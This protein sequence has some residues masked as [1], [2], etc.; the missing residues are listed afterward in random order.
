MFRNA[1]SVLLLVVSTSLA[2]APVQVAPNGRYLVDADGRPF[3]VAGTCT[4]VTLRSTSNMAMVGLRLMGYGQVDWEPVPAIGPG[5]YSIKQGYA[6]VMSGNPQFVDLENLDG[7]F[8][9]LS[10]S[11]VNTFRTWVESAAFGSLETSLG[12]YSETHA[13]RIDTILDTADRYGIKVMLTP[14]D[15]YAMHSNFSSSIYSAAKGGPC[16][17][18]NEMLT[19]P[20]ARQY[21]K[22]LFQYMID[23]W[24]QHPALM[25]FDLMNEVNWALSSSPA[26]QEAWLNDVG[27]YVKQYE[28]TTLG[29]NHLLTCSPNNSVGGDPL[30]QNANLNVA[31][32]HYYDL[33]GVNT[34]PNPWNA[35]NQV[36]AAVRSALAKNPD[37]PYFDNEHS[38]FETTSL[39][40]ANMRETEHCT[41]WA[42]FASGAAGVGLRFHVP[43]ANYDLPAG[44][45]SSWQAVRTFSANID[46]VNF[47]SRNAA[48]Q[49]ITPANVLAAACA[50]DE[51][52][53]GWLLK[54]YYGDGSLAITVNGLAA[55]WHE[56]R[57]FD[58]TTGLQVSE[59]V[60]FLGSSWQGSTPAF[61]D[62]LAFTVQ[63]VPEPA[64]LALLAVGLLAVRRRRR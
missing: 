50:D 25:G 2:E 9:R 47:D 41:M 36:A 16:A 63:A 18:P 48:G 28:W 17:T 44:I 30:H 43:Y 15:T 6:D 12:T 54:R 37:R 56:L 45:E 31:N 61:D 21:E 42:Q 32:T 62:H 14:W 24:G 38:P 22:Q 27:A 34:A 64:S 8:A 49:V 5:M 20:T 40:F 11:G 57:W 53:F 26:Q 13:A 59:P 33:P 19:D 51:T 4:Y 3:L 55:G 7:Y 39:D 60:V 46:W 35:A 10:A 1:L 58:D 23:R 52:L 29:F